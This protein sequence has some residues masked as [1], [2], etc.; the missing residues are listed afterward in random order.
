M[1][2]WGRVNRKHPCCVC[3]KTDWCGVSPDGTLACCMRVKSNRPARNGGWLH[4][5]TVALPA[6]APRVYAPPP[7]PVPPS[8]IDWAGMLDRFARDTRVAEVERLAVSLGVSPGSLSR[9]GIVWVTPRHAWGFPMRNAGGQVIGVRIRT[10]S[11]CKFAIT[12]SHNGLFWPKD[13]TGTGPLLI[14]EGPTDTAALLDLGYDAIG[15]P[16]CAGTVEAVVAVVLHLRRLD[17]VLVADAD[18]AGVDGANRLAQ[19]LTEAGCRPKIIQPVQGKDA[20]AWV[21]AGATRG[22]VN[23]VIA[24]ALYWRP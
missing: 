16:S 1:P 24:N 8:L 18:G 5:I 12:G 7:K 3:G 21:Q 9:L 11:G 14:C 19:M 6:H 4:R 13:L 17:V 15:R 22:A 23:A 10:K 20:R 2:K